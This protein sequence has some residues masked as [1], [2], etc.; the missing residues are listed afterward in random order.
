MDNTQLKEKTLKILNRLLIEAVEE[1]SFYERSQRV[2]VK[3]DTDA[4]K[5]E[6]NELKEVI[7]FVKAWEV[8]V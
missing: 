4:M 8:T 6:I 1:I 7:Q 2:K 5:K 3:F